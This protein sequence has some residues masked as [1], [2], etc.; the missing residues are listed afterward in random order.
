MGAIAALGEGQER[1]FRLG[2]SLGSLWVAK[3]ASGRGLGA[4]LE[5]TKPSEGYS[6]SV[7]LDGSPEGLQAARTVAE[8]GLRADLKLRKLTTCKLQGA[9]KASR[10]RN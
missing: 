3:R 5:F 4:N 7:W 8:K 1:E 9:K 2:W 10:M 6:D